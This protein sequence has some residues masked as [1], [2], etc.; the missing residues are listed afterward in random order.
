MDIVDFTTGPDHGE[1]GVVGPVPIELKKEKWQELG[2]FDNGEVALLPTRVVTKKEGSHRWHPLCCTLYHKHFVN[3]ET[4]E[5]M[6]FFLSKF[7]IE[8]VENGSYRTSS[9]CAPFMQA[10]AEQIRETGSVITSK[11]V[12][13]IVRMVVTKIF[14]DAKN[15]FDPSFRNM[16]KKRT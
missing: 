10:M 3:G 14:A 9:I 15:V 6:S 1:V 8:V 11:D 4:L 7:Y 2:R 5:E 12:T 13:R 16:V